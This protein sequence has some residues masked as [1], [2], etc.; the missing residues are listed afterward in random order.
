MP[1]KIFF[2]NSTKK[3]VFT[4]QNAISFSEPEKPS[5]PKN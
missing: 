4:V 3:I 2:F 1:T 5:H